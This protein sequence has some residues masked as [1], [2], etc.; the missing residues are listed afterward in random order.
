MSIFDTREVAKV[1]PLRQPPIV[2]RYVV[3][4]SFIFE[5]YKKPNWFNR[6]MCFLVFGWKWQDYEVSTTY[7]PSPTSGSDWKKGA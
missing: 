3:G 2:G 5:M 6:L 7:V 1:I 4:E